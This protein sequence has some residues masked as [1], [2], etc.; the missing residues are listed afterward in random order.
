MVSSTGA[1]FRRKELERGTSRK[2]LQEK[3][4]LPS[5]LHGE[6]FV[7]IWVIPILTSFF[8]EAWYHG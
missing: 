7:T 6:F 2:H 5:R 3:S 1:G 4:I 8:E